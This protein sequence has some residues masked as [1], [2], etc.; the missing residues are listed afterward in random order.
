MP[1]REYRSF[2]A[3][4]PVGAYWLRNSTGFRVVTPRRRSGWV[5]EVGVR[6]SDGRVDVIAVRKRGLFRSRV[7]I[8]PADRVTLV[9]PWDQT[10]VLAPK[11]RRRRPSRSC[12]PRRCPPRRLPRRSRPVEPETIVLPPVEPWPEP[13]T[14]ILPVAEPQPEPTTAE[15]LPVAVPRPE[16]EPE[17]TREILP[18]PEPEPTTEILLRRSRSLRERR[19]RRA[20]PGSVRRCEPQAPPR[21]AACSRPRSSPATLPAASRTTRC[22]FLRAVGRAA[23]PRPPAHPQ[24]RPDRRPL[25][26]RARGVRRRGRRGPGPLHEPSTSAPGA[27]SWPTGARARRWQESRPE[28]PQHVRP[29]SPNGSRPGAAPTRTAPPSR[30]G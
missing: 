30:R 2:D 19:S 10:I 14:E 9:R 7:K 29:P 17:P 3:D 28:P 5:D 27:A 25:L 16:T 12:L 24:A 23:A 22:V 11:R 18:P 13:T 21:A 26:R 6:E 15:I 8:V 4:G 20:S 1:L